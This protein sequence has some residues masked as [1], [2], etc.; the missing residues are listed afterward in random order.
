MFLVIKSR[1]SANYNE[2]EKVEQPSELEAIAE[3]LKAPLQDLPA[4]K[5]PRSA[6]KRKAEP[7]ETAKTKKQERAALN[8]SADSGQ[9]KDVAASPP[10][11]KVPVAS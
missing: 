8:S 6:N 10:L 9:N 2:P 11:K 3:A 4:K 5:T 1:P 7:K